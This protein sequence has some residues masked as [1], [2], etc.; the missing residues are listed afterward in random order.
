MSARL[1]AK[2]GGQGSSKISE[3]NRSSCPDVMMMSS[4]ISITMMA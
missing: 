1:Y 3:A 2:S 4:S